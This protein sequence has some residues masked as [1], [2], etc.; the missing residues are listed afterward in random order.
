M[1]I[2]YV[3]QFQLTFVSLILTTHHTHR[4]C[5]VNTILP[6]IQECEYIAMWRWKYTKRITSP[7]DHYFAP[8]TGSGGGSLQHEGTKVENQSEEMV[9]HILEKKKRKR[10]EFIRNKH[11]Q[12]QEFHVNHLEGDAFCR[13]I[14]KY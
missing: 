6:L 12:G 2:S 3:E 11:K 13:L 14:A 7:V 8:S 4:C 1:T 5:H 9:K 10:R